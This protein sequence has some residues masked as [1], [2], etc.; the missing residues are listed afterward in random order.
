M[1]N[2]KMNAFQPTVFSGQSS[3]S[4]QDF[5]QHFENYAKLSNL[6]EEDKVT[7]FQLLLKGL[8]KCWFQGLTTADKGTFDAINQKFKDSYLS[9]SKNWITMQK[10]ENRR[11]RPGEKTEVYIQDVLQMANNVNMTENEQRAALIR[12]LSPKLRAQLITH[13]NPQDLAETIERINLSETALMLQNEDS[14]NV[15]ESMTT[16]QLAGIKSAV[17]ELDSKIN[18]LTAQPRQDHQQFNNPRCEPSQNYPP[19]PVAF[20]PRRYQSQ[21]TSGGYIQVQRPQ[22]P[23]NFESRRQQMSARASQCYTCGGYLHYARDC[24]QN[25]NDMNFGGPRYNQWSSRGGSYGNRRGDSNGSKRG[26]YR[27]SRRGGYMGYQDYRQLGPK[28]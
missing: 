20:V 18:S 9:P 11:L 19:T 12:G 3:E 23:Q 7:I 21:Q 22:L 26:D 25:K 15:V 4:A 28:N 14:V 1:D 2:R 8:A 16:C 13:I 10:L 17:A 6:K 24:Y 27:G 5:L